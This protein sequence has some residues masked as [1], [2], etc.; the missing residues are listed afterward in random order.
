MY[1]HRMKTTKIGIVG[2]GYVGKAMAKLFEKNYE[3]FVHYVT[4]GIVT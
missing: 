3:V 4:P 2:Y 1:N